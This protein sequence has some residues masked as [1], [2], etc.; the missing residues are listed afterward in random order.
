[1]DWTVVRQSTRF[2]GVSPDGVNVPRNGTT[3][4]LRLTSH[5]DV[6]QYH[7]MMTAASCTACG[8]DLEA[9]QFPISHSHPTV[10]HV[11]LPSKLNGVLAK[12]TY[13]RNLSL[14]DRRVIESTRIHDNDFTTELEA[15]PWN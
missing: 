4:L 14:Q 7:Y 11:K 10:N 12:G 9:C 2:P 13:P 5:V 6:W 15:L 3:W 1:M 8:L